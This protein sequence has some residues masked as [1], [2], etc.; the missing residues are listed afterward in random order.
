MNFKIGDKVTVL[1]EAISGTVSKIDK[2][3]IFI[4]L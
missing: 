3:T 1:D 2:T 4:S